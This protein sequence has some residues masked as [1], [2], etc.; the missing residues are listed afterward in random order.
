MSYQGELS[1]G[2][3]WQAI[4][5]IAASQVNPRKA[6]AELIENS[7]D[8]GAKHILITRERTKSGVVLRTV[9]DGR[10]ADHYEHE[11]KVAQSD[12]VEANLRRIPERICDSIKRK[13]DQKAKAGIIGEFGIG[14]LGFWA[15]G[16]TLL[17]RSRTARSDT[18]VLIMERE[19]RGFRVEKAKEPLE[20]AGTE[21]T[22]RGLLDTT[23]HYLSGQRLANYLAQELRGRLLETETQIE[24]DD[25]LPGGGKIPVRP[26]DFLGEPL[27]DL[28]EIPTR[29]GRVANLEL[30]MNLAA[31]S[32]EPAEVGL[33]RKGT[34]LVANVTALDDFQHEPWTLN[35][36]EG[37]IEY[38]FLST[39]P[40]TRT[41]V[42]TNENF[43]E[44]AVAL[45]DVEPIIAK[46][47]EARQKELREE[48]ASEYTEFLKNAFKKVFKDLPAEYDFFKRPE[49]PPPPRPVIGPLAKVEIVP[50]S[51][52]IVSG[53]AWRFTAEPMDENDYAVREDVTFLWT[54][55][56]EIG[57]VRDSEKKSCEV[58]AGSKSGEAVLAVEVR[59][60]KRT[61]RSTAKL[62]VVE[63]CGELSSV[64]VLPRVAVVWPGYS[65]NLTAIC[66][67][68]QGIH[69]PTVAVHWLCPP[70]HG[71]FSSTAGLKATFQ[72]KS[73]A[74]LGPVPIKVI[75]KTMNKQL[76][77]S[78]TLYLY[79]P[80]RLGEKFPPYIFSP[81]PLSPWRSK[82]DS[83]GYQLKVNSEHQD[84]KRA[85]EA[86]TDL[87][88]IAMLYS[89]ELVLMNFGRTAPPSEIL[90]RLVEVQSR[91]FPLLLGELKG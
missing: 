55:S 45:K 49:V 24:I 71:T 25:R 75:A 12:D 90:E 68:D 61:A 23:K 64:T 78:A 81:E 76:E 57:T 51:V 30:Y 84:Y 21:V 37:K 20:K 72:A 48:R 46:R 42:L 36:L 89:K 19:K 77:G 16:D 44:L 43:E 38:P 47:I 13:L 27:S 88:Y 4:R 69:I 40:G 85:K 2:D 65:R 91:L 63:R 8:A 33:Y 79:P 66:T 11:G 7:I 67:D 31:S 29:S 18:Y 17:F 82:W 53:C 87:E 54:L 39:S 70:T 41:G 59:Q 80:R 10:G 5:L 35:I 14:I 50:D 73:D 6:V 86:R 83:D 1:I 28:T 34:R 15:V 32:L 22:I 26:M 56:P 60:E 52:A 3:E 74:P 9:D 62:R 58:V